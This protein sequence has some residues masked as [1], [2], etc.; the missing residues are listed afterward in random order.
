M[1]QGVSSLKK[2]RKFVMHVS[3]WNVPPAHDITVTLPTIKYY[4]VFER[5]KM[6]N[7]MDM[8]VFLAVIFCFCDGLEGD[9]A[10]G[11]CWTAF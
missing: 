11:S 6:W 10:L 9:R 4:S 1:V 7:R 2:Y 5:R 8:N 3:A